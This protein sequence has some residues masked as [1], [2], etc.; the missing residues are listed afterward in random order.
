MEGKGRSDES[1]KPHRVSPTVLEEAEGQLQGGTTES[2][3]S[4]CQLR[5]ASV[6]WTLTPKFTLGQI[7]YGTMIFIIETGTQPSI[8]ATLEREPYSVQAR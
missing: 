4:F 7:G 8:D 2:L 5:S 1:S 6:L 3:Q